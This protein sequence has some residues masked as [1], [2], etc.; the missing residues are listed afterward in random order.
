MELEIVCE[1]SMFV[2]LYTDAKRLYMDLQQV[3][4]V[5]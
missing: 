4:Q 3:K 1:I 2:L 5:M